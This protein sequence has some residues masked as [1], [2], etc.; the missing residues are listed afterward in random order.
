VVFAGRAPAPGYAN[1]VYIVAPTRS[2][3]HS[4]SS[5]S[6]VDLREWLL[7]LARARFL[8]ILVLFGI[9]L[10]LR[11]TIGL[12]AP[13]LYF[14]PLIILWIT[15][16]LFFALLLRSIP[17]PAENLDPLPRWVA[18]LQ[19]LCDLLMT[20]GIVFVT[21]G[22]ESYFISLYILNI[23]IASVLFKRRGAF[24]VAGSSFVLLGTLVE[25]IYYDKLPRTAVALPTAAALQTWLVNNLF[26]FV[27]VAYL[28]SLLM[29]TLRRKGVEL[30]AQ[31]EELL[32]LR[33]FNDDIIES[34]RGGLLTTDVEGRILLLNRAGEEITGQRFANICGRPL[35]EVFP[36]FLSDADSPPP[37]ETEQRAV[38]ADGDSTGAGSPARGE[39][40]T[41]GRK[42]ISF[43]SAEGRE[44]FL[45]LSVS[46]LR[47]PRGGQQE[48]IGYVYNFQ[49]VTELKRL[50]REVAARDRMAALG[51]LSAAIA[52]EIRQPLTAMAGSVKEL[53]RLVPLEEDEQRLVRIVNQESERLNQIVTDVLNYSGE[54][55]YTFT[56]EDPV[57][58]AEETLML[59]E[60]H[61]AWTP[62]HRLERIFGGERVHVR[63]D[64]DRIKQV[65]WN[66]CENA[67]RAMPDGGTLT[68]KV[69]NRRNGV[70]I[71]FRD[72]GV[73][74]EESETEKIFEPY[75]SSFSGGT[76]LGLAIVYE[77][78]QAHGG[79]IRVVSKKNHGAEF[80]VE[81]PRSVSEPV[82]AAPAAA[83][84]PAVSAAKK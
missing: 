1:S 19:V 32:D 52:H 53:A 84:R 60:R 44:K 33:A 74:L 50:E 2:P 38:P 58:L 12:P 24:L 43:R 68:I 63:V 83:S 61:P 20:T 48:V 56:P 40:R 17:P 45:G 31:R 77:I 71:S 16:A 37:A 75:H 42:E 34:M 21:G 46:P 29:Q 7:W 36:G 81:L 64:R 80:L 11:N 62:Q 3:Q 41:E 82:R 9:V 72:T 69:E 49:D 30:E 57:E 35:G 47:S 18:P 79:R 55:T 26:Y 39:I 51:R 10:V 27:A 66:L 15:L 14:A 73:G 4:A 76:G 25:L 8:I 28:S 70:R 13:T 22:H 67:L 65:F 59:L 5:P 54:K 78:V 23:I 6:A